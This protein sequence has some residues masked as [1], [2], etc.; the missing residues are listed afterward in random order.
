MTADRSCTATFNLIPPKILTITRTGSGN[1]SVTTNSNGV[2]CGEICEAAYTFGQTV[3]LTATPATGSV[4]AGWSG[5]ADCSDGS[6]TM[7]ADLSCIA[8]FQLLQFPVNPLRGDFNATA[9][10]TYSGSKS[11]AVMQPG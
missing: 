3:T 5:D 6:V 11:T 8:R 1:G 7:T 10:A 9:R 4:F 2:D